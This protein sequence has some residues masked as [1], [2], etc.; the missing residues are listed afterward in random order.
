VSGT[1][2]FDLDTKDKAYRFY[3]VWLKLPD[4]GTAHVNEVK[5]G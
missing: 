4:G 2:T 5:T 1:T 3:L